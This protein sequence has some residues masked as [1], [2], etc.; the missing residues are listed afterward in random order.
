[1]SKLMSMLAGLLIMFGAVAIS[2]CEDRP[3]TAAEE[4]REA[5][6]EV[7]DAAREA[8]DEASDA[9]KEGADEVKDAVN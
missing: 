9:V 6:D 7:G 4:A 5:A 2:G 1:M 3:D 8:A